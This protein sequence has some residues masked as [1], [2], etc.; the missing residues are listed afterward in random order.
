LTMKR[1]SSRSPA[2]RATWRGAAAS[3]RR[4]APGRHREICAGL[5]GPRI[6]GALFAQRPRLCVDSSARLV[7]LRT[8]TFR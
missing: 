7:G 2:R 6:R 3:R 5:R 8:Q 4:N 1:S